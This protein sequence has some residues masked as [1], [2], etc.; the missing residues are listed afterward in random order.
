[1]KQLIAPSLL[2]ADFM[3]LQ[4][5]VEMINQSEADWLHLDIMDGV[6]V[7]NISF[8]FPV[9]KG[10]KK[11][12]RKPMDVHLMI[13]EPHKFIREV[14]ETG[15]YLMNVHYE[16]CTHLHRTIAGIHEAGMKAG[17]TL[18][19]HSPVSLLEDIVQDVDVVMLM[20]VNPGYGGQTFIEHTVEK[21]RQL[22]EMIDRKGLN[23]LIEIDGGVNLETGK[24]LLEAG[25]DVLVA[26]S[27]VFKAPD[28]N[29]IIKELKMLNS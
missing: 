21:T 6:F 3:N 26:G 23:T 13:V 10:L 24:R 14:A 2:A 1:M 16:A 22:R 5:D 12:C 27:F 28:P 9:L 19:P 8:G 17:V 29:A 7:P 25:A 20:S 15:A 11:I 4:R 18:N